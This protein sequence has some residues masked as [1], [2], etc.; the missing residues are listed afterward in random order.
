MTKSPVQA[1]QAGIVSAALTFVITLATALIALFS[2]AG[3]EQFTDI[4]EVAYASAFLGAVVAGANTY[5]ARM[6]DKP[7]DWRH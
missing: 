2:Q 7:S 6:A 5:K 4:S 1:I 3:V